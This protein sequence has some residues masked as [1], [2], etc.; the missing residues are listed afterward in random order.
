MRISPECQCPAPLYCKGGRALACGKFARCHGALAALLGVGECVAR[1]LAVW[2]EGAIA[3]LRLVGGAQL[4]LDLVEASIGVTIARAKRVSVTIGG[5][6]IV[7]A[8]EI[9]VVPLIM[10][11]ED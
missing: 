1:G 5:A 10:L 9:G 6:I 2:A 11:S 3:I 7:K 8:S 4:G